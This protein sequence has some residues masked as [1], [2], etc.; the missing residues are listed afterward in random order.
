MSGWRYYKRKKRWPWIIVWVL[1]VGVAALSGA[2]YHYSKPEVLRQALLDFLHS[3]GLSTSELTITESRFGHVVMENFTLGKDTSTAIK[4]AELT[5]GLGDLAQRRFGTLTI[6]GANAVVFQ[7]E[8]GWSFGALDA[9]R[10]NGQ[11]ETGGP[12]VM[13]F[14]AVRIKDAKLTVIE[15][16]SHREVIPVAAELDVKGDALQVSALISQANWT[17]QWGV[18]GLMVNALWP[19]TPNGPF[20]VALTAESVTSGEGWFAPLAIQAEALRKEDNPDIAF[21]VNA[22]DPSGRMQLL[23]EGSRSV[24]GVVNAKVRLDP[25]TFE[26]GVIQPDQLVPRLAGILS[27]TTGKVAAGG[28][29]TWDGQNPPAS[30]LKVTL[31]DVSTTLRSTTIAGING[32]VTVTGLA[33]FATAPDQKLDVKLME[34]GIPLSD[35]ALVFTVTPK[36]ILQLKPTKWHWAGGTVGTEAASIDLDQLQY[37]GLTLT[38]DGVDLNHL[39][40]ILMKEGLTATGALQGRLPVA[41]EDGTWIIRNGVLEAGGEGTIRYVPAADSPLQRSTNPQVAMLLDALENFHYRQLKLTVQSEPSGTMRLVMA[42]HGSNPDYLGGK[43]INLNINLEGKLIDMI[44]AEMNAANYE[45]LLP[46]ERQE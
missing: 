38:I 13:P 42:I 4:K 19:L 14:S 7:T 28:T 12:I 31:S 30:D 2:F 6:E 10:G 17:K 24:G 32:A 11:G 16:T 26:T 3:R 27:A 41:Y 39:L 37:S 33:P 20:T 40:G 44:A 23:V 15:S 8:K 45:K 29:V 18:T 22:Q 9:F 25:I 34:A 35:G 21:S 5:Y 1:L 36:G 46:G 43:A